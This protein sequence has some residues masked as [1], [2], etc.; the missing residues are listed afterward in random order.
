M[1]FFVSIKNSRFDIIGVR[2]WSLFF[3]NDFTIFSYGF[4]KNV[5][6]VLTE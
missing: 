2:T 6:C 4:K 3:L 1:H 5:R